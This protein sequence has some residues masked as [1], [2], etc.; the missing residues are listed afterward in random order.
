MACIELKRWNSKVQFCLY[1]SIVVVHCASVTKHD[2]Y[3]PLR[4]TE[5]RTFNRFI[6]Y[7]Q[8]LRMVNIVSLTWDCNVRRIIDSL[9]YFYLRITIANHNLF[10]GFTA[11]RAY[12]IHEI[13]LLFFFS[14]VN[15]VKNPK[16]EQAK[17]LLLKKQS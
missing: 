17:L 11:F 8:T 4:S 3:D 5:Y 16:V 10:T 2:I 14:P 1:C 12:K 6:F 7:K 15:L 13:W 9:K